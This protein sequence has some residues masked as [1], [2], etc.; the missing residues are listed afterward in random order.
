MK[1]T[2]L[3]LVAEDLYRKTGNN[4]SRTAIVFPNKRASLFFKEHLAAQS[5]K[6]IWSPAYLSISELF[7]QFSSLQ[8]GDSIRLICELYK[9][10]KEETRAEETLDDFYFWGELLINDFDDVD[11]NLVDAGQLFSN[12]EELKK[13]MDNYDFLDKEQEEAIQHFFR[14]F[15]I[16]QRTA[17]KEKFI[18]LWNVLGNIYTRYRDTLAA[19]GIGYEGMIQ[20]QAIETL[21]TEK[22]KYD[23]YVF[24]GFNA[25][26][27]V[28]IKLFELL[29]NQGKA[30]FYWDYDIFYTR[31]PREQ[32]FAY[33]HEAGEFILRNMQ[34]F[35]NELPEEFFDRMRTPK[36]IRI[37]SSSTENAQVRYLPQWIR[38]VKK[39]EDHKGTERE[40][41]VVLCNEALLLPML[42]A[43][44]PEVES[45]NITMGFPLTQTPAYSFIN[46]IV[47]LQ[48]SGYQ[49]NSGRYLYANVLSVLRHPY[50]RQLSPYAEEVERQLT[51][52]NRFYPL[53]SELARDSFLEQVFTPQDTIA[54]LCSQIT[55]LL[56][57]VA[58]LYQQGE[59][60]DEIFNQLYRESLFKGYTLVNRLSSLIE[61]GDLDVQTVTFKRLLQKLLGSTGIPFHGEPAIGMQIMGVLETR[62]LDFRNLVMLSVN[63]KQLP[64]SENNSSFIPYNLRKAFGMTT[65]EHKNAVYAYHFYRLIQRAENITLLYN[66][67]SDGLSSG[68]MSRFLLQLL[69]E[70]PHDSIVKEY[71]DSKQSPRTNEEIT[72]EKTSEIMERMHCKYNIKI[73]PDAQLS[74]SALNKYLNCKLQFYYRYVAGLKETN[75]VSDEI[76]SALFGSIFHKAAELVYRDLTAHG[77]EVR[78]E[79]LEQIADHEPKL[80]AYIDEAFKELF[81]HIPSAAK[82]EY[83]GTQLINAKV[84]TS[85][86]RQLLKKDFQYAPFHIEAL[87]HEVF[88]PINI[89]T[90]LGELTVNIGG[91]IDRMDRKE[92]T[93]RIIDYKTGGKAE[94]FSDMGQLFTTEEKHFGHMF[95][96]FLYAAIMCRK[97]D[98]KVAPS[99][100]YIHRAAQESYS[101]VI[102]MRGEKNA[103]VPINDFAVLEEEFREALY[104]LLQEIFDPEAPFTPTEDKK[105][106]EYC[107]YRTICRR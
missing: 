68:E 19:Q 2:F 69:V 40:N 90:P 37:I 11:K 36:K 25:L 106:C 34:L 18:L 81:F 28:E 50:T 30:L 53:P 59:K 24:V 83:N 47:E 15:S 13:I 12:L 16:E 32:A 26:N 91:T 51:A 14:N 92:G 102:E 89:E 88:E 43:I 46:A 42:H 29:R 105:K 84:L 95:Q 75:D 44:P 67:S 39:E 107:A 86:L 77:N 85:Y 17:L 56:R 79:D 6:P 60:Q 58:K 100:L 1:P 62:N 98:L 9:I 4:L 104:D 80:R 74:P 52:T 55:G 3:Q 10:F 31:L 5:D 94:L 22:L 96:I 48:T 41:A 45:V 54:A 33:T 65:I 76:D 38:T 99:L 72:I 73:Y 64:R 63:E 66:S 7:H 78:K 103:K 35:P 61:S 49:S 71:L 27:K 70:Y 82:A 101:P 93:L 97:Q 20:R 23:Q 57:E 21:N 8:T 87:E